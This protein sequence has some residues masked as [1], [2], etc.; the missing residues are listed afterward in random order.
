MSNCVTSDNVRLNHEALRVIRERSGLKQARV[1]E[2]AGIDR[3]NY[4]HMEKG[5]RPGTPE[6]IK[7]LAEVLDVPI[8]ALIQS[9]A[10]A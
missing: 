2:R 5:R 3:P 4:N 8:T 6:Q 1:A 7:A 9:E 10:A